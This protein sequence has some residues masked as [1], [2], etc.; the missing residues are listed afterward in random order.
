MR[1]TTADC[2]CDTTGSTFKTDA[3]A[4]YGFTGY[5]YYAGG[6]W[7]PFA[8]AISAM[9][10]SEKAQQCRAAFSA[11][12][13]PCASSSSVSLICFRAGGYPKRKCSTFCAEQDSHTAVYRP[14][15][16]FVSMNTLYGPWGAAGTYP[17]YT[18]VPGHC[19]WNTTRTQTLSKVRVFTD[20][21]GQPTI[22]TVLAAN[23]TEAGSI[24]FPLPAPPT[25]EI[26]VEVDAVDGPR[27]TAARAT[28]GCN[29]EKRP[30]HKCFGETV[31]ELLSRGVLFVTIGS[32]LIGIAC[33]CCCFGALRAMFGG[34]D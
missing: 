3:T 33:C 23:D 9:S 15:A 12:G 2:R 14:P 4:G 34:G 25:V 28:N 32:V 19:T 21:S 27:L 24:P 17:S 22:S 8:K 31:G 11:M 30:S 18:N 5:G 7:T 29:L 6:K 13:A 26:E 10:S 1:V 20:A 16:T